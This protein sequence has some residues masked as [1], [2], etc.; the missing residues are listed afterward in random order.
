LRSGAFASIS[1]TRCRPP[2]AD[3]ARP[4][5]IRYC[6]RVS[7]PLRVLVVLAALLPLAA[8]GARKAGVMEAVPPAWLKDVPV[9]PLE[10][11][12]YRAT[13]AEGEHALFLRLSRF[14]DRLSEGAYEQP[15]E[16]V[17]EMDGPA[18]GEDLPEERIVI[19]DAVIQGV[20]VS[21]TAGK[22]RVVIEL[23]TDDVPPY[24]V[25]EAADWISVRV[26]PPSR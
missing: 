23:L 4:G 18:V 2:A 11:L 13:T 19:A 26:R 3:L 1:D 12:E 17:L 16:I 25:N 21:R 15:P 7:K 20:R 22:L 8:C 14:P 24:Q 5:G 6:R 10:I 9:A